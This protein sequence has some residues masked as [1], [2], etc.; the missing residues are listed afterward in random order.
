SFLKLLAALVLVAI[1]LSSAELNIKV[2]D[3]AGEP[4]WARLEVRDAKGQMHQPPFALRDLNARNR[5]GGGAW[6]LGSF[7]AQG[8]S[9]VEVP[10]GA[11]TVIAERGA[12]YERLEYRVDAIDGAPA[13]VV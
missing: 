2:V 10:A 7:V 1:Q 11:Y 6:Y 3:A 9:T 13:V 8:E 4:V 12:E 5:P